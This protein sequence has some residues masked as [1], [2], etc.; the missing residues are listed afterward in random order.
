MKKTDN[1]EYRRLIIKDNRDLKS[2]I[3]IFIIIVIFFSISNAL[4]EINLNIYIILSLITAVTG[5]VLLTIFFCKKYEISKTYKQDNRNEKMTELRKLEIKLSQIISPYDNWFD[6]GNKNEEA[7]KALTVFL[8]EFK[9]CKLSN[10]NV[11]EQKYSLYLSPD[12]NVIEQNHF[13]YLSKLRIKKA[14]DD[15]LYCRACNEIITLLH[16]EP[17]TQKRVQQDLI[18]LLVEYL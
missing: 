7:K 3:F 13:L 5:I 4:K 2:L 8:E 16:F 11:I 17:F 15:N 6:D 10:I 1:E 18:N 12:I 14:L 9:K